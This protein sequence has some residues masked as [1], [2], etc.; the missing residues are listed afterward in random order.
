MENTTSTQKVLVDLLLLNELNAEGCPAC[1]GR[2]TLGETAVSGYGAWSGGTKYMHEKE[3]IFDPKTKAYFERSY[4]Q[5][6]TK[7]P[8]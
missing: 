5:T 2:F 6:N 4:Y 3:A 8:K 7:K 1:G